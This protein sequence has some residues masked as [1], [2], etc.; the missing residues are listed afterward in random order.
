MPNKT[1]VVFTYAP[2]GLGHL[3]VVNALAEGC[4]K[5]LP[6]ILLGT[7]DRGIGSIHNFISLNPLAR[8]LME[9]VQRG[10]PQE[11]FTTLYRKYLRKSSENLLKDI[12]KSVKDSGETPD[13]ILFVCAH[14]GIAHKLSVI[15][16][17]LEEQ[18]KV[19]T[20]IIVQVTDDSPQHIWYVPNVDLICVPS[21]YTKE[22]LEAYA[23]SNNLGHSPIEVLPYPISPSFSEKLSDNRYTERAMQLNKVSKSKV[24]ICIPISGAAVSTLFYTHLIQCLSQKS[25]ECTFHVVSRSAPFTY[26]FIEEINT[27]SNV[28]TYVSGSD[29]N[30][31]ELYEN[32]YK[33]EVIGLEITKPSEQAF[34]ALL[35]SESV[36]GSVLLFSSPVGRQE[37]DNIDFLRR[38]NLIITKEEQ[39][40][41]WELSEKSLNISEGE[42]LDLFEEKRH[43]RGLELPSGSKKA[44][45]FI[46]WCLKQGLFEKILEQGLMSESKDIETSANGVEVFWERVYKLAG[47][48]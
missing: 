18:L 7:T 6:Y 16:K 26:S 46:W 29:K 8:R 44:A 35:S 5:D 32:L 20:Y 25:A 24:N 30:V 48:I 43:L 12:V 39:T 40:R 4:K 22:E 17:K 11:V 10:Q 3:R 23:K 13:Q 36:G 31:V 38:H 15:R 33:N 28:K 19:N 1:L 37:Y 45:S 21:Q 34:K 41:L 14:F 2:A 42:I 47:I 27:F 9:W